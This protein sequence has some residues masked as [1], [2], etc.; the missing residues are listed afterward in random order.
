MKSIKL[1][2][3][4]LERSLHELFRPSDQGIYVNIEDVIRLNKEIRTGIESLYPAEVSDVNEE[5]ALCAV[6]LQAY[7]QLMYQDDRD[8]KRKQSLLDRSARLLDRTPSSLLRCRLLVYCYGE[9]YEPILADE[10]H[11]IMNSWQDHELTEEEL[12]LI[13]T[14]RVLEE[15]K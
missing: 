8:E 14:L 5:A 11:A 10:A 6:L 7:G 15:C 9:V 3:T 4:N 13:E 1:Q 2:I 12:E